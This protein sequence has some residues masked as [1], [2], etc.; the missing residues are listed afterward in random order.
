MQRL[1]LPGAPAKPD[2]RGKQH[3]EAG[4]ERQRLHANG[5]AGNQ[6][7]GRRDNPRD[8][9]K[10]V[11]FLHLR[12]AQNRQDNGAHRPKRAGFCRRGQAQ[13][14][15]AQHQEDQHTRRDDAPHAFDKQWPS[16]QRAWHRWQILRANDGQEPSIKRE[17]RD[18][19]QRR[20][21]GA[22]VHIAHGTAKLIGQHHQHQ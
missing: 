2:N 18:L 14:D 15:G 8:I 22:E 19:Q 20:P 7:P 1:V 21:P 6:A 16:G 9:G 12:I 17:K 4:T 11:H 13:H 5:E 10:A 3:C